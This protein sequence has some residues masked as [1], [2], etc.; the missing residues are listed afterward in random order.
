MFDW[1]NLLGRGDQVM[2]SE[3]G[4]R[5][6]AFLG[7]LAVVAAAGLLAFAYLSAPWA[8]GVVIST[9]IAAALL[10][11]ILRPPEWGSIRVQ[12][13]TLTV[14]SGITVWVAAPEG[15][16]A[17]LVS[18]LC[19]LGGVGSA[20][21]VPYGVRLA[22]LTIVGSF[23]MA[24][25]LIWQRVVP[26]PYP[27]AQGQ[28]RETPFPRRDYRCLRDR[29]CRYMVSELDR[30][31]K[32]VNWS[33][34][35]FT[36]LE[37]EVEMERNGVMRPGVVRDLVTAIRRDRK[38]RA[39]LVI[40]DPGSG[41]SVSLRR[42]CRDLYKRVAVTG[43][44]PVYVN[45]REW[46]GPAEPTDADISGFVERYLRQQA[47]REGSAFLKKW[48]LPMLSSGHFFFILDSF[49]EMPPVLDC[50]DRSP[51]LRK[52]S[53][54]L[55]RFLNDM[56]GCR[57]VLASRPFRQPAGF[58][59]RR[60]TIRPF[61]ERQVSKA[62][63]V[64][65][66]GKNLKAADVVRRLFSEMPMLAPAVRNPFTADLIAQYVDRHG[67]ELPDG[68]YAIF[69]D[70]IRNRLSEEPGA[71]TEWGLT[72]ESIEDAATQ[73]AWAMY[74]GGDIGL[75]AGV[76]V[77]ESATGDLAL[78]DKISALRYF[79]IGRLG[80]I[81]S[82][83][84]SFVHRRFAEFFVVRSLQRG[85]L[86]LD[87][88]A[89]PTDSRWR[90]CLVVYCGIAEP[91]QAGTI[92]EY[93]WSVVK[94]HVGD[95]KDG[96]AGE[97]GRAIHCLRF[98]RDAFASR[99]E[100]IDGFRDE[101]SEAVLDILGAKDILTAKIAAEALPMLSPSARSQG[102]SIA[103]RRR[104]PWI[105]ETALRAC[106]HLAALEPEAVRSIRDYVRS[107]T[108]WAFLRS[109]KSLDFSL[110]LSDS[111]AGERTALRLDLAGITLLGLLVAVLAVVRPISLLFWVSTALLF[112]GIF[113]AY[114]VD[115]GMKGRHFGFSR[116][117]QVFGREGGEW[118]LR[119][120][121]IC[122]SP[123]LISAGSWIPS[124]G[125]W[126][127]TSC[128]LL[129]V[130]LGVVPWR[131]WP[132]LWRV[133]Q[134]PLATFGYVLER[135]RRAGWQSICR[136]LAMVAVVAGAL[137]LV[138]L[139]L[140]LLFLLSRTAAVVLLCLIGAFA[141][142]SFG[143]EV[144]RAAYWVWIDRLHLK[145]IKSGEQESWQWVVSTCRS[146]RTASV[147]CSFLE[148][149]RTR[150]TRVTDPP[151]RAS[152]AEWADRSVRE[153]LARLEEMWLELSE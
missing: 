103:I 149:L 153:Q 35:E 11:S 59:G 147:R 12:V 68:Y 5:A 24:F 53:E 111:L 85:G 123:M 120:C 79:R 101:L 95:L 140:Y 34:S 87:L 124:H 65:L 93:C 25:N 23:L 16:G 142:H 74:N 60:L 29:F 47:G 129:L 100:C 145:H 108:T 33:D 71:L 69:D 70:H 148:S 90:D 141:A 112:D 30:Y 31:D 63:K 104:T 89:I 83:K 57:G 52:I 49:D 107:I 144:I 6:I 133:L 127:V 92:A 98:L 143:W 122:I 39:F 22:V 15:A 27:A 44:V 94:D 150:R 76:A 81:Q 102:I 38:S 50:D 41:K 132:G 151:D 77:L 135:L 131:A 118:S 86:P 42:L 80:G 152:D 134:S 2:R 64:W 139:L 105:S 73:I 84:F 58:R 1:I 109:F 115:A 20:P 54:A 21:W 96:R 56:H 130:L 62:M 19:R 138:C 128:L 110:S 36:R 75:E 7:A 106:R 28:D 43:V 45:L 67:G 146:F 114:R 125:S 126:P 121:A 99:P 97:A 119:Y 4:I 40:G 55:D 137:A 18:V 46:T 9:L 72:A 66:Q 17:A 48:Y 78:M 116:F 26:L 32:E 113:S 8:A 3:T 51:R 117:A 136:L 61:T 10:G 91:Q 37:A 14:F 82:Q 13:M 88:E